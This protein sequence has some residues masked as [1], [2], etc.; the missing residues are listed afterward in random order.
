MSL[1]KPTAIA[2]VRAAVRLTEAAAVFCIVQGS[3][4]VCLSDAAGAHDNHLV[5]HH[6]ER[7]TAISVTS[8]RMPRLLFNGVRTI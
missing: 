3:L 8:R 6:V 4:R 2:F 1:V 5:S 7:P